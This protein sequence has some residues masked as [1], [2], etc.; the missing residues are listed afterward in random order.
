MSTRAVRSER[1]DSIFPSPYTEGLF[2]AIPNVASKAR[3][4]TAIDGLMPDPTNLP[5]GCKFSP[6]CPKCMEICRQIEPNEYE[7]DGHRIKCHL[8]GGSKT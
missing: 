3:R 1:A 6:R 7:K 8:F 5:K 4:L 2:G